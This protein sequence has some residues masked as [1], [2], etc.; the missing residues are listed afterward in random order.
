[1]SSGNIKQ[2]TDNKFCVKLGKSASGNCEVLSEAY[3]T[4]ATKK[5][6]VFKWHTWPKES[7]KKVTD[8]ER[9]DP[10]QCQKN[11]VSCLFR[12]TF[13]YLMSGSGIKFGQKNGEKILRNA[14][15]MKNS[16]S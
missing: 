15:Y 16:H 5:L 13:K 8:S 11:V 14:L 6:D 4:E 1:M 12:Q 3:G 2:R 10:K 9:T 7:Q